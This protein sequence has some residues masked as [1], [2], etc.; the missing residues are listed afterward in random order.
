LQHEGS[1]GQS[2]FGGQS[3]QQVAAFGGVA[4]AEITGEPTT[5]NRTVSRHDML[6]CSSE[7]PSLPRLT[8]SES[9]PAD[10]HTTRRASCIGVFTE[11]KTQI[12]QARDTRVND[13]VK[14]AGP[15]TTTCEDAT[16][17]QELK[18]IRDGLGL[19]ANSI[20]QLP[21]GEFIRPCQGV[22]NAK[23]RA[24]GEDLEQLLQLGGLPW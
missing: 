17:R 12:Q 14:D 13:P 6:C 5:T 15:V 1:R 7:M 23:S 16:V 21:D 11:A 18:L 3:Q 10:S 22:Q 24:I 9:E 8:P 2:R 4:V 19:H 20:G